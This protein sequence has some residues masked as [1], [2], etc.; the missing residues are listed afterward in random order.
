MFKFVQRLRS[1]TFKIINN[2][3]KYTDQSLKLRNDSLP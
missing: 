2:L 1:E 3:G